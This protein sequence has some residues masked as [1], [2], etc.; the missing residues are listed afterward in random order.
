[1][2]IAIEF[3]KAL[4]TKLNY[5][6][7]ENFVK[8]M[9]DACVIDELICEKTPKYE[10]NIKEITQETKVF[11]PAATLFLGMCIGVG[12][13]SHSLILQWK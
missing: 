13:A 7:K 8:T 12:L 11:P 6:S 1:M 10:K 9:E 5:E 4:L 3:E 2:S